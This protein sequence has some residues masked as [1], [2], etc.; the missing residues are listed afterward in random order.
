MEFASKLAAFL[1]LVM[2][3]TVSAATAAPSQVQAVPL[4]Q[5]PSI[6]PA[7]P[8]VVE[9]FLG[10]YA[11]E[12]PFVAGVAGQSVPPSQSVNGL[13]P[14]MPNVRPQTGPESRVCS[15]PLLQKEVDRSKTYAIQQITPPVIDEA[16]V[17][18][19]AAPACDE[20]GVN[21]KP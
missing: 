13:V 11:K 12:H 2:F 15:I 16:M 10:Q 21:R 18:K 8:T 5:G 4:P 14:S 19:P 17:I 20:P 9:K 6:A 1:V 3:F 7:R